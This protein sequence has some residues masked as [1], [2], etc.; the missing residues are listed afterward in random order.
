MTHNLVMGWELVLARDR[1]RNTAKLITL[2]ATKTYAT[3]ANAIKAVEKKFPL[4]AQDGLRYFLARTDDDR[5]YP[6]FVGQAA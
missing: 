3:K 1:R 5:F 4:A 6:V 2:E